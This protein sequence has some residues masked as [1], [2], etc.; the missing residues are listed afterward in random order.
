MYPT[1][2]HHRLNEFEQTPGD[3]EGQGSLTC[4]RPRGCN[5]LAPEQQIPGNSTLAP[6]LEEHSPLCKGGVCRAGRPK[7]GGKT[8]NAHHVRTDCI[9]HAAFRH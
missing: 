8:P 1:P 9:K 6:K 7:I 5:D 2:G 3:S 4:C